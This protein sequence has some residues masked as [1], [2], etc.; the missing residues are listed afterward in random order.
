[1]VHLSDGEWKIMQLLWQQEPWTITK[2]TA[3][4][5]QETDWSKHTVITMLNRMVKKGAVRYEEGTRAKLYYSQVKREE[6]AAQET[7]G[8][9]DKVYAGSLSLMVHAMVSQRHVSREE[10]EEIQA[11]L[12]KAEEEEG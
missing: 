1:M 3:A 6:T 12:K 8:F 9:L 7:R 10:L 5:Q 2:L 11:I 4:L